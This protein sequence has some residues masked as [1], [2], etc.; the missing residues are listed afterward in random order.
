MIKL[1]ETEIIGFGSI[2]G[3][4]VYK[5]NI[6]NLTIVTGDNGAGKTSAFNA[7]CWC[8]FKQSLKKGSLIEP[9]H[10]VRPEKFNGTMVRTTLEVD[11]DTY[12]IIRCLEYKK[13]INGKKG[14]NSLYLYKGDDLITL[15]DKNTKNRFIENLLGYS[16]DLF[17]ASVL[18]GQRMKSLMEEDGPNKKKVLEEAFEVSFISK[19]RKI[20]E[21][22]YQR[23][24]PRY[25][26]L[27]GKLSIILSKIE[28]T[29]R[30]LS[31][32]KILK[33]S[34]SSD[35]KIKIAKLQDELNVLKNKLLEADTHSDK[36]Q[37]QKNLMAELEKRIKEF[38]DAE[39]LYQKYRDLEF[40]GNFA[41][42]TAEDAYERLE[43]SYKRIK[44]KITNF[45]PTRCPK[46][47]SIINDEEKKELIKQSQEIK[48]TMAESSAEIE[49]LKAKY[50][51]YKKKLQK[52]AEAKAMVDDWRIRL[53]KERQTLDDL[54]DSVTGISKGIQERIK[55]ITSEIEA[56]K[57]RKFAFSLKGLKLE[58]SELC[59]QRD[60]LQLKV[61]EIQKSLDTKTWLL[62]D[63]LS[64]GG[65]KAFIFDSMLKHLNYHL[66][67]YTQSLGFE[68]RVIVDLESAN[69]DIH[70]LIVRNGESIMFNDLSGG[71]KQLVNVALI[72]G[73]ND[74]VHTSKPINVLILDEVFEG[75]NKKNAQV[76]MEL[77][78]DKSNKRN[79]HLITHNQDFIAT[80]SHK[81]HFELDTKGHTKITRS[82]V[83]K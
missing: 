64:N 83:D 45:K 57:E 68:I 75:L 39:V 18:I 58:L 15:R 44:D 74:T 67:K 23:E 65:L 41:L 55:S 34:F 54:R 24:L 52:H 33:E 71:Q 6:H 69:K 29:E 12:T 47:K 59:L 46:C 11:N 40:R 62:K 14:G 4:I 3:P 13:K 20:T 37:T 77:I 16:F 70:I 7:L 19:A 38:E 48:A 60:E 9:W 43:D 79:V 76:V 21:E 50:Q 36:I 61:D 22:E 25:N 28:S 72:F 49:D 56:E 5:W 10:H 66:L 81:I 17:K 73:L 53:K 30:E 8:L 35:K 31:R 42:N 26:Q 1:I 2:M 82:T 51:K 78:Q 80:N 32:L 27:N 63:P